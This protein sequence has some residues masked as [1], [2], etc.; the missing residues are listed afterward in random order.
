MANNMKCRLSILH[1]DIMQNYNA[2]LNEL[3]IMKEVTAILKTLNLI[4]LKS[5]EQENA[6]CVISYCFESV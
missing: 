3:R 6:M 5:H 2:F 1:N 4:S